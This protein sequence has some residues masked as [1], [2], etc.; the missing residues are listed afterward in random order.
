MTENQDMEEIE[1]LINQLEDRY[2]V[3]ARAEDALI[4]IGEAAIPALIN[5]FRRKNINSEVASCSCLSQIG[6]KAIPPLLAVLNDEDSDVQFWSA[7]TLAKFKNRETV[8]PL[9]E[10]LLQAQSSEARWGFIGAL[11]DIGDQRAV[12]SILLFLHD[13]HRFVR[14]TAAEA[15]GQLG[16]RQAIDPLIQSLDDEDGGVRAWSAD[17]LG[18]IGDPKAVGPLIEH[19]NQE[20]NSEAKESIIR[21]LGEIGHA[22]AFEIILDTLKNGDTTDLRCQAV[23]ALGQ[24]G[25]KRAVQPLMK[26]IRDKDYTVRYYSVKALGV[27]GDAQALPLLTQIRDK[28]KWGYVDREEVFYPANEVAAEA[29]KQIL[30]ANSL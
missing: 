25:D 23:I 6:Q 13:A 22:Q 15:L 4:Q 19:F 29:I 26:A 9:L 3:R 27:L 12:P 8:E 24:L 18:K 7:T 5:A 21:A 28:E 17:A 14:L 16:D 30:R 2:P 1:R 10:A 20:E 11:G